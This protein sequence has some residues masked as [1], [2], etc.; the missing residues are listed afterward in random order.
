M[1]GADNRAER[2]N[3]FPWPPV[4]ALVLL[5]LGLATRLFIEDIRLGFWQMAL[6]G[7]IALLGAGLILGAF[8]A[9]SRARSNILP[10]KP[11]DRLIASG[12]F[13]W[14]RNPIYT[15]EIIA[16]FGMGLALGAPGLIVAAGLLA[17]LVLQLG[18]KREEAHLSAR[19]GADW[20][21]YRARVRRWL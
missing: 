17:I 2:P 4:L 18:V 10:H 19:F 11:A 7:V 1:S 16:M 5:L 6:G 14:S 8:V 3:R 21:A 20:E 12:V 13:A 9:F 15:G